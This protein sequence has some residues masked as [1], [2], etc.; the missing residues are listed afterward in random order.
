MFGPRKFRVPQ[1]CLIGP[2]RGHQL[3]NVTRFPP[4]ARLIIE[5]TA[6]TEKH[7]TVKATGQRDDRPVRTVGNGHKNRPLGPILGHEEKLPT[8][9]NCWM[10]EESMD[11]QSGRIAF[12]YLPPA[13]QYNG[14]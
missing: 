4:A 10:D 2:S 7:S 12:F 1:N 3:R 11:V 13:W 6:W 5:S 8:Y 9:S 14:H